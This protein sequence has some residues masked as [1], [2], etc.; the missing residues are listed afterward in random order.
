MEVVGSAL[1]F[2]DEQIDYGET[3]FMCGSRSTDK[4]HILALGTNGR[5]YIVA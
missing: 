2:V 1:L 3:N 5:A 4:V